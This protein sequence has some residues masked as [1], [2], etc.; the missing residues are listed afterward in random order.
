[1]YFQSVCLVVPMGRYGCGRLANSVVLQHLE[2][3]K[4]VSGHY[5]Q[6]HHLL[7]STLEEE[8]AG[9]LKLI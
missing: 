3:T 1:M 5:E 2:C 7:T 8:I 6:M 4:M 9:F